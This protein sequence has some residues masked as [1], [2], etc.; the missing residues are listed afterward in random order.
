MPRNHHV[1]V[2]AVMDANGIKYRS[3]DL[4]VLKKTICEELARVKEVL[5]RLQYR[6]QQKVA[7][8]LSKD[9]LLEIFHEEHERLFSQL[10]AID[11]SLLKAEEGS[12]PGLL[13]Q[14]R[15]IERWRN[16]LAAPPQSTLTR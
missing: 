3:Q 1:N 16:T 12:A 13:E 7:P 8:D 6:H 4:L 14:H 2:E 15:Q 10:Q 11:A 9:E 5:A